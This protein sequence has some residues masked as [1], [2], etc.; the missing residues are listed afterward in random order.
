[1]FR[2]LFHKRSRANKTDDCKEA[3]IGAMSEFTKILITSLA[4]FAVGIVAE[5]IKAA[6]ART[7]E[8]K[9]LR[10]PLYLELASLH[11]LLESS[12][13]GDTRS[14]AGLARNANLSTY[15]YA[16]TK[17][18]VFYKIP[19]AVEFDGFYGAIEYFLRIGPTSDKEVI[20]IAGLSLVLLDDSIQ[21]NRFNGE[22]FR[23]AYP[24]YEE[25]LAR[26]A[27]KESAAKS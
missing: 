13:I 11:H 15:R 6:I 23:K 9:E 24:K 10:H 2:R 18:A 26:K 7:I 20:D 3:N 21:E 12:A 14:S 1:M 27:A 22:Q 8:A 19:E 16:K 5:P 4:S 17:P 25:Y